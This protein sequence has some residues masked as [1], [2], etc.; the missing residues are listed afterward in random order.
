MTETADQSEL[1]PPPW[2]DATHAAALVR[3]GAYTAAELVGLA[4][5][6]ARALD[7]VL[8]VLSAELF[9]G[10]V[11]RAEAS[12]PDAPFAGVPFLYKDLGA[13]EAGMPSY[14]G[15]AILR[16]LGTTAGADTTLARRLRTA[17]VV[18]IGRTKTPELGAQPTTQPLAFGP[19]RNP[20]DTAR[21]TSG[22][23]GGSAAAVAAGI[24][25]VAH[26][27]DGYGSLRDPASWCGVVGLKPSRGRQPLGGTGNRVS[28]EHVLTRSVR[29]SAS[30][31][32]LVHGTEAVD[33]YAAPAP[34][35]SFAAAAAIPPPPLRIG[36]LLS[37]DGADRTLD[38]DCATAAE[39]AAA[40]LRDL[41]HDVREVAMPEL[42]EDAAVSTMAFL[43]G[44][45]LWSV[46]P[47]RRTLGRPFAEEEV[48]P[49]TW[50]VSEPGRRASADALLVADE[51]QQKWVARVLAR[52][53]E[54]DVLVTPTT[55][56]TPRLLADLA[57]RDPAEA[58]YA[59]HDVRCLAAPFNV[60][61]Q[62]AISLPLHTTP[63]GLPVGVQL[64]GRMY[65]E[66]LLLSLAAQLESARPWIDRWPALPGEGT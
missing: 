32:D 22:S 60:T 25:P 29:D 57:V 63:T 66:P 40:L 34:G 65:E 49:Y 16:A 5:R 6:R 46:N 42:V 35:C 14:A 8:G 51:A 48:E 15:N 41:G 12:P 19:C 11:T 62:P 36:A 64:V 50:V 54:F 18:P 4:I 47:L 53:T 58:A 43:R 55:A 45:R 20:W 31:L 37:L 59:F 21:S 24:V 9:D 30:F 17:G 13:A 44:A 1:L 2:R 23:S 52:W 56:R 38:A 61:G 33:R 26:G 27:T 7:P 28:T 39:S 10:A 3:T